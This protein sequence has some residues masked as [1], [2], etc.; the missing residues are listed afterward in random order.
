[1][2]QW[3][4]RTFLLAA[5]PLYFNYQS[6]LMDSGGNPLSSG[7]HQV[8][9]RVTDSAH[10]TLYEEG[11]TVDANKGVVA[12]LIGNGAIPGTST[13][14]A[15]LTP[16]I[17]APGEQRFLEVSVDGQSADDPLEIVSVPYAVWTEKVAEGG[18]DAKAIASGA[19]AM[20][21]FGKGL[22]ED[23]A[24]ALLK[25]PVFSALEKGLSNPSG[26]QQVGVNT[27][28]IY[29]GA[30]TVQ[31]VLKDL[32]LAIKM[33]EEKNVSKA[34]DIVTG[35]INFTTPTGLQGRITGLPEP[36]SPSDAV[37]LVDLNGDKIAKDSLTSANIKDG[38]IGVADIGD[39]VITAAKLAPGAVTVTG[40]NITNGSIGTDKLSFA[41]A[42]QEE[43][44]QVKATIQPV[45]DIMATPPAIASGTIDLT[46]WDENKKNFKGTIPEPNNP[47]GACTYHAAFAGTL[48][49]SDIVTGD[50]ASN[51]ATSTAI[52]FQQEG[53]NVW[54]KIY[55][56]SKNGT[57]ANVGCRVSYM[58]ICVKG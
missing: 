34:G 4:F 16:E 53:N 33:R 50:P 45:V 46:T 35:T 49:G 48:P 38:T 26:A 21:H 37:R 31:G 7:P 2:Q 40:A 39:G 55:S 3:R 52:V 12:T 6:V 27:A 20:E 47:P 36:N 19:I 43:L 28:F 44:N 54:C 25:Q 17:F 58:T 29:S 41:V 1:M 15:G 5:V 56:Y 10:N 30:T 14:T 32:D 11:Q 23:L 42:T 57:L 18:V 8:V 22:V 24:T 51:T 9:F 13:P